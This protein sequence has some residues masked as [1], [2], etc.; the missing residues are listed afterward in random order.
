VRVKNKGRGYNQCDKQQVGAAMIIVFEGDGIHTDEILHR[1]NIDFCAKTILEKYTSK[2]IVTDYTDKIG[3][4]YNSFIKYI[5]KGFDAQIV[6]GQTDLFL[7]NGWRECF[8]AMCTKNYPQHSN[9]VKILYDCLVSQFDFRYYTIFLDDNV[10]Y[11]TDYKKAVLLNGYCSV[12][13]CENQDMD[14]IYCNVLDVLMRRA[15]LYDLLDVDILKAMM[16]VRSKLH[17]KIMS[18]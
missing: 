16:G 6:N 1:L 15:L 11:F 10:N 12:I 5:L 17:E 4:I 2:T 8:L 3:C 9:I 13:L 18:K 7:I 14:T